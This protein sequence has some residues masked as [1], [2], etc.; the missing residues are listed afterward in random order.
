MADDVTAHA[1]EQQKKGAEA[2]QKSVEAAN[3]PGVKP[4][5]TQ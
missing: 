1:T 2:K 5:P 4:T 3:Q